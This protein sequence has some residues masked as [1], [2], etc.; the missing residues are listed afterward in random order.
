MFSIMDKKD[1]RLVIA[2]GRSVRKEIA[3]KRCNFCE[4][5][6]HPQQRNRAWINQKF[7]A[8][9][10][11]RNLIIPRRTPLFTQ[12][13]N[14]KRRSP[15]ISPSEA[16]M[17]SKILMVDCMAKPLER[18]I[19]EPGPNGS[20]QGKHKLDELDAKRIAKHL[21]MFQPSDEI[22]ADLMAKAR[23][24]IPGL[25]DTSEIQRILHF[26]PDCIMAVSR[27]SRFNP[28]EPAGEGII[29]VLP[30]NMLGLQHLT[31]GTF[32]AAK[33]DFRLLAKRHERPAGLYMWCV[34]TPGPLAAAIALFME[35][36]AAAPYAGVSLYSRPNTDLGVNY[37]V[38]LGLTKGV[39]VG[40][41]EAPNIWTF[42][43]AP[44]TPLYDTYMPGAAK[45]AIGITVARSLEDMLRVNANR[46][47][48]YIGEQQCPYDEEYDGNDISGTHLLAYMG[49][50]PIGCLRL[51]FFA[52]FAKIERLAVRKEFRKSQAAFQLV[53]ASFKFCQKKGY[54]RVY[55]HSQARLVD[56]WARFGLR[57]LEGG[58][59]FVFSDFDYVEM[60]ADLEPDP[61][62]LKLGADPYVLIR[63]EGRWHLPGVLEE[64]AARAATSP[65]V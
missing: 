10:G 58:Q 23:L 41:I 52:E 42:S 56:F 3:N 35:K 49:D 26:N 6:N 48:V 34:Y 11:A 27:K 47:A 18:A 53:R 24:A 32:N 44:E 40:E 9:L 30:L 28:A 39:R 17:L 13:G 51:R 43:R 55:A 37:N 1:K 36:F 62:A 31:L 14:L 63:P 7:D 46:N 61:G 60:V 5:R 15:F 57:E 4:L 12:A 50:E 20:R 33:P 59:R 29:C 2:V 38:T 8:T 19:E 45:D 54:R 64:S 65:S 21:V 16:F 22:V 25:T